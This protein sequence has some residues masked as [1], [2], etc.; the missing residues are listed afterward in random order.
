[1][2]CGIDRKS[3]SG[4]CHF[5]GSYLV[6]WLARKQ[7]SI[8]QSTT[9]TEYVATASYCSQILW[10]VQTMRDYG[11][12]YKSVSLMCDS[13]SAICLGQNPVF[14][15][16]AKHIKVRYHFLRDHVEKGD[17]VMKYI[18]TERQLTEIFNKPLMRLILLLCRGI[19]VFTIPMAWFEGELVFCIVYTLSCFHRIAFH[20]IY[21]IYLLRHLLY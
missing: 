18:D 2:G 21:Q 17:I 19:M 12:T 14:H 15:D 7:S 4:T 20:H 1:V 5:L 16:R 13:S 6:C 11:V 8:T 10:I 3:T 9:K